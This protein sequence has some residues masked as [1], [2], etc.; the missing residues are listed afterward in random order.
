[1]RCEKLREEFME[2]VLSGPAAASPELQEH[3]RSC[4]ACAGELASFQQTMTL[5]DEWPAPGPSPYFSS[6]LRARLREE[7]AA[8]ARSWLAW[9]RR[10]VLAAAAAV[11]I[12]VGAGLLELGHVSRDPN[13][14][15]TNDSVTRAGTPG[16]AVSDLQYLDKNADLFSEFDALDGQS[17]TE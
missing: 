14:L 6:R 9:L 3:L 1:M 15:A 8:P 13:T 16:S 4:P 2:A 17:S 12:A 7:S 11:L 5:L 10:P